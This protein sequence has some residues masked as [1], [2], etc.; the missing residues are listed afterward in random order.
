MSIHYSASLHAHVFHILHNCVLNDQI[1]KKA[2]FRFRTTNWYLLSVFWL[3]INFPGKKIA[4]PQSQ[5][6]E[7]PRIPFASQQIH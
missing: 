7:V 3:I 4:A 5:Q 6:D 1:F 2:L